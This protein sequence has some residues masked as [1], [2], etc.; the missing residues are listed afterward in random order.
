MK[1]SPRFKEYVRFSVLTLLALVVI[2]IC[3]CAHPK[4]ATKTS[5]RAAYKQASTS[6]LRGEISSDSERVLRR[7]SLNEHFDVN[8][9][10][11]LK[12]LHDQAC[13]DDRRDLLFALA[14]LSYRHA[15]LLDRSPKPWE[16]KLARD[17]YLSSAI[18]AYLYLFGPDR[19]S[20]RDEFDHRFRLACDFYNISLAKA[21]GSPE[22]TNAVVLLEPGTRQLPGGRVEIALDTHAFPYDLAQAQRFLSADQFVVKGLSVRN[23]QSGMG[24]PLIM[25]N[26]RE[27]SKPAPNF[28]ATVF[29]RVAGDLKSWSAGPLR[30]T[31]EIYSAYDSGT[32][33]VANKTIPLETDLTAPLAYA[34]NEN[35]VWQLDLAQ[36]FSSRELVKSAVYLTEPYRTDRI[37]VVF[38]HGTFS[39]PVW[40]AEMMNTLRADPQIRQRY[41]F[42]Y[43]IYNS[44]NPVAYSAV[45]LREALTERITELDPEGKSP[46]LKQMVVIGHSQGGLLTKLTAT[47]TSDILWRSAITNRTVDSKLTESERDFFEKYLLYEHLPFVKR[48]VFICTPH[49]GSYLA[50]NFV[51]RFAQKFVKLPSKLVKQATDLKQTGRLLGF[52][53][54]PRIPTSLDS[55]SSNNKMLL[56]LAEIP[57]AP[58]I[59]GNSIIA[60][61]GEGDY[62]VGKDGLVA[63]SSAHVDYVESEFIVR[64]F[65]SCQQ[66]PP[67]IEEVRRILLKHLSDLK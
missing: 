10:E 48:V 49:R 37:P 46:A 55:M 31:L 44:G 23:R 43:F 21:L 65:H 67:T 2:G 5:V 17:V 38:V 59:K 8:P 53:G 9:G 3:G 39:S 41:Q 28:P 64:S 51:R 29:L 62:H 26:R 12:L 35:F 25:V 61:Q 4:G 50:G 6:A 30:T 57:L 24:A 13:R 11:A 20:A 19:E 34:L 32:V 52:E 27:D 58:G 1:S 18:Y 54:T 7:Y 40:W 14:E 47:D 22:R 42:W 16:P 36:F 60:V 33:Q 56:A 45:K 15:D 66:K 63:Y